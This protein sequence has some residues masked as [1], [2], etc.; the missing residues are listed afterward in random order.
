MQIQSTLSVLGM[1]F[2]D[3]SCPKAVAVSC[4]LI[5]CT[6]QKKGEIQREQETASSYPL[7]PGTAWEGGLAFPMAPLFQR[8]TPEFPHGAQTEEQ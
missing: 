1:P 6:S 2:P 3:R 8:R 4:P 5:L 7:G